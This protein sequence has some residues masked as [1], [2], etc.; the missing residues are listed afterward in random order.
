VLGMGRKALFDYRKK[1]Y[2]APNTLICVAGDFDSKNALK[3]LEKYFSGI[4]GSFPF[5]QK[6]QV[7]EEQKQPK[8]LLEKRKTDQAHFSLGVRAYNLFHPR[9]YALEVLGVILGGMMSSRLFIELREK[10]GLCYYVK[11]D[12]ELDPDTGF[13]AT[14]AGVDNKNIE[15]AISVILR[16]YKRVSQKR[17]SPEELKK[18]KDNIKGKMALS[19]ESSDSL[20]GFYALQE[21]M[22]KRIL[23]QEEIFKLINRVS[24]ADIQK[25]ARDIFKPQGLNLVLL[26]PFKK[27]EYFQKLLKF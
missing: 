3:L 2:V 7:I 9:R 23:T 22:E 14:S 21:L 24:S 15:K 25:T 10:L 16:E 6:P 11:T 20:A 13:L 12:A 1:Q 19:L 5:Y 17:I 8:C 26:G 4:S 18:A 27:Q